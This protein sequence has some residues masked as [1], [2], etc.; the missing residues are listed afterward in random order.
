MGDCAG[1]GVKRQSDVHICR[2]S[3]TLYILKYINAHLVLLSY[4]WVRTV[5]TAHRTLSLS[6]VLFTCLASKITLDLFKQTESTYKFVQKSTVYVQFVFLRMITARRILW[7]IFGAQF[8]A[9]VCVHLSR[10]VLKRVRARTCVLF[11]FFNP[12]RRNTGASNFQH[13]PIDVTK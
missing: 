12:R 4:V 11:S 7:M 8:P 3:I 1:S 6:L 9:C 10:V 2:N 13:L 5:I